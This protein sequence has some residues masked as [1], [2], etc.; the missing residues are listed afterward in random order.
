MEYLVKSIIRKRTAGCSARR[1]TFIE[2]AVKDPELDLSILISQ[3]LKP[4][5]KLDAKESNENDP[6]SDEDV[7][8]DDEDDA[9]G[10]QIGEPQV[11]PNDDRVGGRL[12]QP[13]DDR[14]GGR[15][16]QPNDDR[17]GGPQVNNDINDR[18]NRSQQNNRPQVNN[19][20]NDINDM[21][22][23]LQNSLHD[24]W[25]Q[26]DLRREDEYLNNQR[27]RQSVDQNRRYRSNEYDLG[28]SGISPY[29]PDLDLGN[30]FE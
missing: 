4:F 29:S 8:T 21:F 14:V 6:E 16:V 28:N 2:R 23:R 12:V 26:P 1:R 30:D 10:R 20:I 18:S 24:D 9:G 19:D 3:S 13:N 27:R 17:V 15:R 22:D 11:Q 7:R 25:S 5:L